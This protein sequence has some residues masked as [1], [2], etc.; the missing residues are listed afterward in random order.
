MYTGNYQKYVSNFPPAVDQISHSQYYI[1]YIIKLYI[2]LLTIQY[3][4]IADPD[5]VEFGSGRIRLQLDYASFCRD[6]FFFS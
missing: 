1:L 3:S 6:H 4:H 5:T 2:G